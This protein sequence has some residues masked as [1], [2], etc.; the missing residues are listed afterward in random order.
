IRRCRRTRALFALNCLIIMQTL[1]LLAADFTSFTGLATNDLTCIAN[2]FALIWLWLAYTADVGRN[3]TDQLLVDT[4]HTHPGGLGGWINA[5]NA[6]GN[7]RRR[8]NL[9]R[10]G[11]ANLDHQVI[12]HLGSAVTD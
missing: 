8:L 1:L 9:H 4:A 5:I 3:L 12:A 2:T 11:V 7:A 10:V 6:K